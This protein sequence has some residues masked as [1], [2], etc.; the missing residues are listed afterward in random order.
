[1]PR[2]K[3]SSKASFHETPPA[4]Q[5][6]QWCAATVGRRYMERMQPQAAAPDPFPPAALFCH[7]FLLNSVLERSANRR[8]E[9]RGLTLQQWLALGCIGHGGPQGVTHSELGQRLM[10][11]KAPITGVVDRLERAGYV[12]RGADARDRRVSRIVITPAGEALWQEVRQA[13]R[14]HA[15]GLCAGLSPD[16]Q[17]TLLGLLTR[18]LNAAEG[19]DPILGTIHDASELSEKENGHE[20]T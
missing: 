18:L 9:Q 19:A 8:A 17:Q 7:I 13:L 10:L 3:P 1:M 11:S 14:E 5:T 15:A 2:R 6:P 4:L 20:T 16:E 12:Q